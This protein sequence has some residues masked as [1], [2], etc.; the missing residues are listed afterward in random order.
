MGHHIVIVDDDAETL[1]Y[2]EELLTGE[3]YAV[4]RC[5]DH[6]VAAACV[7]KE[8]PHLVILDLMAGRVAAGWDVFVQLGEQ[9]ET[10]AIPVLLVSGSHHILQGHTDEIRARGGDIVLKPYGAEELLS[11]VSKLLGQ[12]VVT[13]LAAALGA[14]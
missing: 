10:A 12:L 2:V 13:L 1:D 11:T 3:G 14:A 4:T 6:G 8:A 9:A 7:R 5:E